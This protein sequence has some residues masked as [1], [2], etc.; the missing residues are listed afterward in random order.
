MT[1]NEEILSLARISATIDARAENEKLG[2]EQQRGFDCG[3][4]WVVIRPANSS[5]VKYLKANNIGTKNWNGGWYIGSSDIHT[6]PTQSMSVHVKAAQEFSR[7]LADFGIL[8]EV[9]SRWD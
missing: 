8:A 5:F 4:G 1:T 3:F 2:P 7:V 9:H 6:V